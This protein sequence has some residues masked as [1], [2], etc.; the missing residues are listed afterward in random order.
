MTAPTPTVLSRL[1]SL[2]LTLFSIEDPV[3]ASLQ[4]RADHFSNLVTWSTTVVAIGVILEGVEIIHDVIAWAKRS[5]REKREHAALKELANIFPAGEVGGETE[6]HF[7][8]PRWVARLL[9]LGLITVVIGVAGEW[10]YGAKLEDAH[11]A[12]HAYDVAKLTAAGEEAGDAGTSAKIAHDE[13]DAVVKEANAIEK[14]LAVATNQLSNLEGEIRAQGPRFRLLNEDKD[15][16]VKSIKP[17]SGQPV[18]V[19]GCGELTSNTEPWILEQVLLNLLREAKWGKDNSP[20]YTRWLS[21]ANTTNVD[22]IRVVLN[23]D[24]NEGPKIAADALNNAFGAIPL[25]AEKEEL[26]TDALEFMGKVFGADSPFAMAAK[27]ATQIFVL[28]G[29]N[30]GITP[31]TSNKLK[32]APRKAPK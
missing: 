8:H 32:M 5:S 9:R 22:G 13:A 17:F 19:V 21:C 29:P 20:G 2:S 12:I 28:V 18:T 31:V 30:L 6:L 3:R 25:V 16:F 7:D 24:S 11:N 27:D 14:R 26:K 15:T 23:S 10:R 4:A 1:S